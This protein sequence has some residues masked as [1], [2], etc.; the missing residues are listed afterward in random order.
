MDVNVSD[1]KLSD[2]REFVERSFRPGR[3]GQGARLRFEIEVHGAA[4]RRS[5]RT[6]S[7]C[8]R[9]SR[10]CSRTR[11]SSRRAAASSCASAARRRTPVRERGT[12]DG[13]GA[14]SSSPSR[15]RASASREDKLRLIF[16]AFQQAD[17]TTSRRY[18]GT[19]LGLSISR[20]I[21]RLLGG[22]IHVE[23]EVGEGSTFTLFLPATFR[24]SSSSSSRER[25][26]GDLPARRTAARDRR[27][28]RTSVEL[29][30]ALLLPS[31][32]ARRPRRR[33]TTATASC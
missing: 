4:R 2:L 7:G 19:G 31:D 15:T 14:C 1:V 11:S 16:E 13:R 17:G 20:E 5:R 28:S 21:A 8:S 29:D 12:V 23:S 32:V 3:G 6:S 27:R 18:G 30:P 33:S 26:A 24:P 25:R 22:E 9:C 10:T